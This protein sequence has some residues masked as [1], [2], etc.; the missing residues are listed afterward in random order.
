MRLKRICH[1]VR[2]CLTLLLLSHLPRTASTSSSS[3]TLPSTTTP[4]HAL[5]SGQHDHL[6]ETQ[7]VINLSKISVEKQRYQEPLWRE[8]RQSDGN[9]R[10]TSST[11][12]GSQPS[13]GFGAGCVQRKKANASDHVQKMDQ[14]GK[15][16][17]K[18]CE[19]W[20]VDLKSK[21]VR[22]SGEREPARR[23]LM[24]QRLWV[25]RQR[26]SSKR[27]RGLLKQHNA[28]VEAGV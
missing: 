15:T 12:P 26:G 22:G 27:G 3:F 5:Q 13:Q 18:V 8:N 9:P 1:L 2:T 6:Q 7:R 16:N 11:H 10:K 28:E 20:Q 24:V 17:E 21:P 4:E 14:G 23:K 19:V 25:R